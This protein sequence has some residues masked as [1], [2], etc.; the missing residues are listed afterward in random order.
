MPRNLD[1]RI[2]LQFPIEDARTRQRV[3]EVL[4]VQLRDTDRARNMHPDGS[5]SRADRRK[6]DDFDS[7]VYLCEKAIKVASQLNENPI[8][9][10]RFVPREDPDKLH[11]HRRE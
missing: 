10:D 8:Y 2:E 9:M 11:D 6:V 3:I 4:S 7:Q 1:R 5:Y